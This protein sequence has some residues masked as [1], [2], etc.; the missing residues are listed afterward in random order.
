MRALIELSISVVVGN[1]RCQQS[2]A[3]ALTARRSAHFCPGC[4]R[5]ESNPGDCLSDVGPETNALPSRRRLQCQVCAEF[6]S[7]K[8]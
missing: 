1:F 5:V 3:L 4:T 2:G 7:G 8:K 6:L